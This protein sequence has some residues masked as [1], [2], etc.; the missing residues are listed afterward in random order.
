[1]S[2]S[3]GVLLVGTTTTRSVR[4]L[5]HQLCTWSTTP[6]HGECPLGAPHPR[7]F[8]THTNEALSGGSRPKLGIG[9]QSSACSQ[10]AC[11]RRSS[12]RRRR[13][14]RPATR[15]FRGVGGD[16]DVVMRKSSE[17]TGARNEDQ[18]QRLERSIFRDP[19][20]D[21]KSGESPVEDSGKASIARLGGS[22]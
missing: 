1:M 8:E 10:E 2:S 18:L 4:S 11:G 3:P 15:A 21:R 6:R 13:A 14:S 5:H 7:T 20:R 9:R 16:G 12:V 17:C 19:G 22:L